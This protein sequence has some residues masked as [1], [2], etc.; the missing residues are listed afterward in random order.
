MS[1]Q[2]EIK[3]KPV[4]PYFFGG[5]N[6]FAQD[7]SRNEG[8]RYS[9]KSTLFPQQ[10]ALLGMLRKTMLIQNGHLTLHKKGEWVDSKGGRNGNDKNYY[11]A[12]SLTGKGA[13][14]YEEESDLGTITSVSPLYLSL[15]GEDYLVNAKDSAYEPQFLSS[16]MQLSQEVQKSFFLKGYNSK[17]PLR[18]EFLTQHSK[19]RTFESI[20][21]EV[22]SVGIKKSDDGQ[23]EEDAFFQKTSYLLKDGACFSFI[24]TFS[25]ELSFKKAFV[26]LGAEQSSF[27]L[28]V[29][30]SDLGFE[31][32]FK[33]IFQPKTVDRL[34]LTSET[35]LSEEAYEQCSFVLASRQ[36]YRQL[37]TASGQK[38]KRYYLFER[39][40]VLYTENIET[41][42][43][44]L[45]QPHLQQAGINHFI[46]VKGA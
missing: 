15:Q 11:D 21:Q 38:S 4:E 30:Q 35:L 8:A 16:R 36:P 40:S 44:A 24:A 6:T 37:R 1:Y 19:A 27:V 39:G 31:E 20:F 5:E 33:E 14:S 28:E 2:Y 12:L 41:L 43:A 25:Q 22:N 9:A 10:T 46:A 34:V 32:K 13:F 23:S 42:S 18:M 7:D 17:K 45:S 26:T 29:T 3:L